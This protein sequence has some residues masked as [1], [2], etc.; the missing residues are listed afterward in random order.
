MPDHPLSD[1]ADT[2]RNVKQGTFALNI[3]PP[4]EFSSSLMTMVLLVTN[5]IIV[6]WNSY[7]EERRAGLLRHFTE[8]R[9]K[10]REGTPERLS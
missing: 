4:P 8:V 7:F 9:F 5:R 10:N 1:S 3:N 6:L 2:S